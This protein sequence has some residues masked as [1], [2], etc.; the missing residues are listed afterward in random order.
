ML[1]SS[2]RMLLSGTA[3]SSRDGARPRILSMA[4]LHYRERGRYIRLNPRIPDL[5]QATMEPR[6]TRLRYVLPSRTPQSHSHNEVIEK[7]ASYIQ[8]NRSTEPRLHL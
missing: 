7:D 8:K 3:G 2:L 6:H 4:I 5:S 1:L